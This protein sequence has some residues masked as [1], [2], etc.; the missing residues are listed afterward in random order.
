MYFQKLV[1]VWVLTAR[2]TAPVC[3][4]CVA[5]S[6]KRSAKYS[7]KSVVSWIRPNARSVSSRPST[8]VVECHSLLRE[9]NSDL[10]PWRIANPNTAAR[11]LGWMADLSLP[12]T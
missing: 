2:A 5:T 9:S 11:R 1:L 6:L 3:M 12:E 4:S 7:G 10:P 8:E